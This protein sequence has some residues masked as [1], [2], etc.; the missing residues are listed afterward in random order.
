MDRTLSEA[1]V[2]RPEQFVVGHAQTIVG[3]CVN[4]RDLGKLA[5]FTLRSQTWNFQ[6]VC[7]A[8][9]VIDE[10]RTIDEYSLV[11]VTGT[12]QEKYRRCERD[13]REHELNAKSLTR[14]G[15]RTARSPSLADDASEAQHIFESI[16]PIVH[17]ARLIEA[18]RKVLIEWGIT[19]LPPPDSLQFVDDQALASL[20]HERRSTAHAQRRCPHPPFHAHSRFLAAGGLYRF[21]FFSRAIPGCQLLHIALC[22]P[23]SGEMQAVL[24]ELAAAIFRGDMS[25]RQ[26]KDGK[27]VVRTG[28][29]I[30]VQLAESIEQHESI[31][32]RSKAPPG[33]GDAQAGADAVSTTRDR[34]LRS[35]FG[36]SKREIFYRNGTAIGHGSTLAPDFA[37]AE[38]VAAML[39][40]TVDAV[41]S[42]RR[43]F[44]T[45]VVQPI[46]RMGMLTMVVDDRFGAIDATAARRGGARPNIAAIDPCADATNGDGLRR[47][48]VAQIGQ[49][50]EVEQLRVELEILRGHESNA[51]KITCPMP[52]DAA[53]KVIEPVLPAY[54]LPLNLVRRL[55]VICTRIHPEWRTERPI[56]L[57]QTLWTLLGSTSVRSLLDRPLSET[58]SVGRLIEHRIVT[59][60]RQLLYLYPAALPAIDA[61]LNGC[62]GDERGALIVKLRTLMAQRPTFFATAAQTLAT[63]RTTGDEHVHRIFDELLLCAELGMAT[64][65][66]VGLASSIVGDPGR[67]ALLQQALRK[68]GEKVFPNDALQLTDVAAVFVGA[69]PRDLAASLRDAGLSAS[70]ELAREILYYLYRPVTMDYAVFCTMLNRLNDR[71]KDWATWGI[72][73]HGEFW[74]ET[75]GCYEYWLDRGVGRVGKVRLYAS[76]NVGSFFAKSTAGICTDTNVELFSRRDHYHLNIIDVDDGRAAGNVQLYVGD[77]VRGRFLLVRGINPIQG[78]CVNQGVDAL[79]RCILHAICDVAAFGGFSEVRLSEQNGLWNS[80]SSRAE[81]RACLKCM[82]A[83]IALDPMEQAFHLYNYY[84]R[85]LSVRAYYRIWE[86]SS[87]Q[88]ACRVSTDGMTQ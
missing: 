77:G 38:Q 81:V 46:P 71:T 59:D 24:G 56:D 73:G 21:A 40:A 16:E 14:V 33:R 6:V 29:R 64:P 44:D 17:G 68:T 4:V 55:L 49:L 83:G 11:E 19:E 27:A 36:L 48:R 22:R 23:R 12:I 58:D 66:L 34:Q 42:W 26:L 52:L 50:A 20:E 57:F 28:S 37:K 67:L 63:S 45:G 78:F 54:K 75:L 87:G 80:D 5:F 53:L 86:S 85:A 69:C 72:G 39:G 60:K 51:G 65:L 10:L 8:K 35:G 31:H 1:H 9:S 2:C 13:K 88:P 62:F 84:D 3:H 74:N 7:T 30:G 15:C 47:A 43:I 70:H 41:A 79:V 18:A 61:L 82:F 32:R 76:K 25:R